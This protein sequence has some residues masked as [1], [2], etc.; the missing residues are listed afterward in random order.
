MVVF[1]CIK[2]GLCNDNHLFCLECGTVVKVSCDQRVP[3][4]NSHTKNSQRKTWRRDFCASTGGK[5]TGGIYG[6]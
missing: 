3:L 1:A 4:K 6:L 5:I 2:K